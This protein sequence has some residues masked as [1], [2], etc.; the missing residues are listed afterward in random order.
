MS[1]SGV[2]KGRFPRQPIKITMGLTAGLSGQSRADGP[3]GEE[4]KR[5][6]RKAARLI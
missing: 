2:R 1:R 6:K 4:W 5:Q 3:T